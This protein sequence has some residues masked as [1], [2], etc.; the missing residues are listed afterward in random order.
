MLAS[1]LPEGP[2]TLVIDSTGLKVYGAG[3]WH[4]D[5]H[6]VRGPRTWHKLRLAVDAASNSIVA[7]TLTTTRDGE[8][9]QVGPLLGQTSGRIGTAM[10]DGTYDGE[11]IHQTIPEHGRPGWQ[12]QTNYGQRAKAETAMA[13][14]KRIPGDQLH[15]R[16]LTG[17]Q[18]EAAVGVTIPN[19][20]IDQAR[21]NSVRTA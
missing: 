17:Q 21:P 4:R 19:R 16:T 18:A 13:R 12:R 10:A 11:P 7:A 2:V 9:S 5:M 14:Y 1:A 15:T 20:M 6:G 3:G 8:A